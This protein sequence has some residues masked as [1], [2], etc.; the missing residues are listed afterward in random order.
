MNLVFALF[1]I[2]RSHGNE[3]EVVEEWHPLL[4]VE[5]RLI[6][7]SLILALVLLIVL[8]WISYAYFGVGK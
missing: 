2:A 3:G 6:I 5:K 4:P 7:Y 1:L 8:V